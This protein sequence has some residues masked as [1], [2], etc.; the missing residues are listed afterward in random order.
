MQN[1]AVVI[2]R[3]ARSLYQGHVSWRARRHLTRLIE[4]ISS[5]V[6]FNLES[7]K[8]VDGIQSVVI[9]G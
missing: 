4:F 7:Q 1:F 5:L 9:P 2:W 3:I 6:V 8:V